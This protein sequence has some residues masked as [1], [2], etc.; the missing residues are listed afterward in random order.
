MSVPE[1]RVETKPIFLLMIQFLSS[2]IA[3]F[4]LPMARRGRREKTDRGESYPI[5]VYYGLDPDGLVKSQKA[6]FLLKSSPTR[7]VEICF[8]RNCQAWILQDP[9]TPLR[10]N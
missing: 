2:R 4:G 1:K 6:P 7:G 5:A 3:N 10:C 8:L 9:Y